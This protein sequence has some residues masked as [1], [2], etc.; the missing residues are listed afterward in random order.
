MYHISVSAQLLD[1][2]SLLSPTAVQLV[3]GFFD[4]GQ[5]LHLGGLIGSYHLI[6]G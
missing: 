1:F 4:L 3:P 2:P 5:N 6:S